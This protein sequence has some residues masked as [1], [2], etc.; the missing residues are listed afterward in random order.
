MADFVPDRVKH[1]VLDHWYN[2]PP[3]NPMWHYLLGVV[4]LSLGVISI[5]GNGL[6]IYLYMKSQVRY[7]HTPDANDRFVL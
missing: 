3:V 2:Y 1:M 4:Y 7:H 6:V 5:A